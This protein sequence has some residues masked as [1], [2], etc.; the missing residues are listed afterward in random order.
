MYK[1]QSFTAAE[2]PTVYVQR[3]DR[4]VVP[5]SMQLVIIQVFYCVIQIFE[6]MKDN[7]AGNP[8]D[9]QRNSSSKQAAGRYI[10]SSEFTPRKGVRE[11]LDNA[12][13]E[14]EQRK[15]HKDS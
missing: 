7:A 3:A 15:A 11:I 2:I 13:H 6:R 14:K 1:G 8:G 10:H 12:E 4:A 5:T 9:S